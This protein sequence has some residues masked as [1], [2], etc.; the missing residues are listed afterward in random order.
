MHRNT[1]LQADKVIGGNSAIHFAGEKE[2]GEV[3]Q[4][5]AQSINCD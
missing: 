1:T 4:Y 5:S 2:K 3:L